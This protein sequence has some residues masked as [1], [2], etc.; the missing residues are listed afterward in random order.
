MKRFTLDNCVAHSG[1]DAL[2]FVKERIFYSKKTLFIGTVGIDINSLFFPM[3]LADSSSIVYKFLI[4]NRPT[5]SKSIQ[6]LGIAH[7]DLLIQKLTGSSIE[8]KEVQII[9]D[10]DATVAGRNAVRIV[11][12]WLSQQK[13]S[14][15]VIDSTGMSRGTCF[16]IVKQASEFGLK[17]GVDVHLLI[18]SGNKPMF[19]LISESNDRADWMHGFQGEMGRDSMDGALKLWVPQLSEG[20]AQATSTMYA[21]LSP[22]AE[23]CPIIPFPSHNPRRGDN[24]LF[25]YKDVLTEEWDSGLLNIIYAHESNPLD[26]YRS[27]S[28]LHKIREQVFTD[29]G[30]TPITILSPAGW[31]IGSLGLLLASIDLKLPVLYV[32][33]IGYTA[34]GSYEMMPKITLP[35]PDHTWHIWLTRSLYIT[36]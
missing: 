16:P 4:E 18:A 36:L 33:T 24:I 27:V 15:I 7:Q 35:R 19:D 17:H 12:I 31:R 30:E 2:E 23:V 29:T 1:N 9:A 28:S 8:F 26:V 6:D 14:D 20:K 10:D 34:N 22:V 3:L 5:V 13:Y 32:E 11:S 21:K 25:E